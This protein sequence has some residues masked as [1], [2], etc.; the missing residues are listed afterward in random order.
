MTVGDLTDGAVTYITVTHNVISNNGNYLPTRN[1]A[2]ILLDGCSYWTIRYNCINDSPRRAIATSDN[3]G[4]VLPKN[5]H[6]LIQYNIVNQWNMNQNAYPW[7][8]AIL[9]SS[10]GDDAESGY[11][12]IDNNVLY[13]SANQNL[14]GINLCTKSNSDYMKYTSVRNN[15]VYLQGNSQSG[16]RCIRVNRSTFL[17][18]NLDFNNAYGCTNPYELAGYTYTNGA[19]LYATTGYGAFDLNT[20]PVFADPATQNFRLQLSSPCTFAGC[21]VG[22]TADICNNPVPSG[23]A[24]NMGAYETAVSAP[25]PPPCTYSIS[26]TGQSF[27]AA[28]GS[29]IIQVTSVSNCSWKAATSANWIAITAGTSGIG[30]GTVKFSVAPN[31]S[32]VTRI[33]AITVAGK[34][35]SVAQGA[36]CYSPRVSKNH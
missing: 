24:P 10:I 8:A 18:S 25:L 6:L 34:N 19:T 3:D 7:N 29:G 2:Q 20:N 5:H 15:I 22:V 26:P 11:N 27:T 12:C 4:T 28:G 17:N 35:F 21:D 9:V 23:S 13:S 31:P 16:S 33:G 36:K 14:I 30:S 32:K 1:N